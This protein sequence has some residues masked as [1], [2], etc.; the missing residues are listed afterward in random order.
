M[1]NVF[2]MYDRFVVRQRRK[3]KQINTYR[4]IYNL[5]KATG[6]YMARI[7]VTQYKL[8]YLYL[9]T[10]VCIMLQ[11]QSYLL[12]NMCDVHQHTTVNSNYISTYHMYHIRVLT[13]SQ[14]EDPKIRQRAEQIEIDLRTLYFLS[15]K[16]QILVG[17]VHL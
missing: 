5:Y 15:S 7:F 16:Y 8:N 14:F 3:N 9:I 2:V 1:V 11:L 12:T 10:I 4:I 6:I 13:P 17:G